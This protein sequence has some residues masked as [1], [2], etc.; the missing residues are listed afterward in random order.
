MDHTHQIVLVLIDALSVRR[1]KNWITDLNQPAHDRIEN[2]ILIPIT[3]VVPSTTSAALTSIWTGR[4]PMEH[5]LLGYELLLK[6]FGMVANMISLSP[7]AYAGNSGSLSNAGINPEQILK[8]GTLGAHLADHGIETYTF[9]SQEIVESSLSRMHYPGVEKHAFL[10]ITDL[11]NQ[12]R[13]LAEQK[14]KK[15]RLLWVYYGAIDHDSHTLGPDSGEVRSNFLNFMQRMFDLF[16]GNLS[17]V[18]RRETILI[19]MA[20]H[21]Q[22]ATPQNPHF[23][24]SNHPRFTERL[25]L[26]PTGENR[27]AYLYPRPG[28]SEAVVEYLDRIWPNSF[29]SLDSTYALDAG[30]FGPGEPHPMARS[31]LGDR[32]AIAQHNAYLWWA[33]KPN[34]LLGRHGGLSEDEMLVPFFALPLG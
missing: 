20:D 2:G 4:S 29:Q 32:I 16:I 3:S 15:Q 30:L 9:L 31:R 6:E 33:N 14:I 23:D 5:G 21:G 13:T 25:H 10:N 8:T 28:Q 19:I 17:Q 18:A 22:I 11:W 34:P 27:L 26:L 1:F 12:V 24:L 7:A